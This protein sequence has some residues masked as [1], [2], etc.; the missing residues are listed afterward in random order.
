MA[1]D[2]PVDE[3]LSRSAR[4]WMLVLGWWPFPEL[5]YKKQR[6]STK[7]VRMFRTYAVRALIVN[8]VLLVRAYV[9]V[10]L[11]ATH[12]TLDFLPDTVRQ[13]IFPPTSC[14]SVA[15]SWFQAQLAAQGLFGIYYK[16]AKWA[17]ND[18]DDS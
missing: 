12:T 8:A 7:A 3:A 13:F 1:K 18:V 15:W 10:F 6:R 9:S 16:L 5:S 2:V 4:L 17:A 14:A 11:D